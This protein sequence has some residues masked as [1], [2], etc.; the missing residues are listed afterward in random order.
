[1][2]N[3]ILT[4]RDSMTVVQESRNVVVKTLE[5]R[6]LR[7]EHV[8]RDF[9]TL[10]E[11]GSVH[12]LSFTDPAGYVA[13]QRVILPKLNHD[14]IA[15]RHGHST[16]NTGRS[17]SSEQ[18]GFLRSEYL[19]KKVTVVLRNEI[20][21]INGRLLGFDLEAKVLILLPKQGG[22]DLLFLPLDENLKH[23]TVHEIRK[24]DGKEEEEGEEQEGKGK[25]KLAFHLSSQITGEHK[26]NIIYKTGGL[27]WKVHYALVVN[28]QEDRFVFSGRYLIN[29]HSG[30]SYEKATV[31][32]ISSP[33]EV[34]S[35]TQF[36][37]KVRGISL[38][39]SLSSL[40]SLPPSSFFPFSFYS[41]V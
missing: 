32:L 25:T 26:L 3:V 27:D 13:E 36:Q 6:G 7:E 4:L 29:N 37:Q 28:Q 2:A 31:N 10:I 11:P 21:P 12:L 24:V 9:P 41:I 15:Q 1:M 39:L 33:K 18:N 20:Q 14:L 16:H 35:L 19:N 34:T 8:L 23:F 5:N 38:P 40:F 30:K 22:G 17:S